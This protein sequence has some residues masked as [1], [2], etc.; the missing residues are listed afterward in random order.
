MK[1]YF[2]LPEEFSSYKNSAV[3]I[4]PIPFDKESS[5]QKGADKGPKAILEASHEIELYD[6]NTNSEVFRKGIYTEEPIVA[7]T[8]KEMI[9]KAYQ[10]ISQLIHDNKFVVSLGGDHSVG[11]ATI[12][13]HAENFNHLSILHLDAH[14][15]MRE[16][17]RGSIYSHASVMGHAKK[18]VNN[19]V[20]VGI[21]SMDISERD[22]WDKNKLFLA[23]D[24]CCGNNH[25]IEKVVEQLSENVYITIDLD[26]FDIGIMPSTGTPEPGGLGW[27]HVTNLIEA[28]CK[29]KN[30]IGCDIV[31]LAPSETNKAPD[32]LVAKLIYQTLSWKFLK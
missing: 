16:S 4:L 12:K 29:N 18:L 6:I 14:A 19:I 17:F 20:S 24:I 5:W 25:W 7:D 31:E 11:F 13:A 23:R 22:A 10:K 9:D 30:V 15:D 1:H 27:Y 3:V 32:F 28:V 2:N 26:V 21:R 8:A